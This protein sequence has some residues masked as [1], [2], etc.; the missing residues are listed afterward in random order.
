MSNILFEITG[1]IAAFKACLLLSRLVKEGHTVQVVASSSALSF[2][3]KATLEGLSGRPVLSDLYESGE[4]MSHIHLDR[5]AHLILVCPATANFINK[6]AH[7]LGDDLLSCLFLAHDFKKPFLI[8]PSMNTM[9]YQHPITQKSLTVLK[10]LGIQILKPGEGSLACGELGEGR[11]MEPEE[12][13]KEVVKALALPQQE[14]QS[15]SCQEKESSESALSLKKKPFSVLITSGGTE[16]KIDSVRVLSN[17]STG[18]TGA[19]LSDFL[20]SLGFDVTLFMAEKA[21][22]PRTTVHIKKFTDFKSLKEILFKSLEENKFDAVIHLAAV[23]DFSVKNSSSQK[24]DSSQDLHL[25]LSRNSKLVNDIKQYSKNKNVLLIA[26]KL[27]DTNDLSLVEKKVRSIFSG[28]HADFVVQNDVVKG[29][30]N[31][32]GHRSFTIYDSLFEKQ[33]C[34]SRLA[35]Y[36]RLADILASSQ[37][38]RE[39]SL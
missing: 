24:L 14:R 5:W 4:M 10:E 31:A 27:T 28:A 6:I 30:E 25:E 7:G 2:V 20:N 18:S 11:L 29:E 21:E 8:A 33:Y 23:S 34:E 16:E 9:M 37:I 38:E 39:S 36:G 12:L 35:L 1:S 13:Y 32:N 3:G 19:G 17:I 15:L 22:K 26:F